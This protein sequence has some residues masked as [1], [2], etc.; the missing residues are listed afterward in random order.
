MNHI[1]LPLAFLSQY[2]VGVYKQDVQ[3]SLISVFFA[4]LVSFFSSCVLPIIPLYMA[5]LSGGTEAI[6]A[7]RDSRK[8][9]LKTM[10]HT[11]FFV[12]GICFAF[13][14]L[15][16]AASGLASQIQRHRLLITRVCG[17]IMILFA[18]LQLAVNYLGRGFSR[19]HRFHFN[20]EKHKMRP[21]VAF[22]L[23]FTFSFAWTPCIGPQLA[24]VL[25][26]GVGASSQNLTY[27]YLAIYC[28]GFIIPFLLLGLF[29][30]ALLSFFKSNRFIMRY[31]PAI[32]AAIMIILGV[33]LILGR[34]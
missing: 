22:V 14:L 20:F 17:A 6:A 25:S 32:G 33:M 34:L 18:I 10:L 19:E 4:G 29:T 26:L 30:D 3:L 24:A 23:G 13:V 21:W 7:S 16:A 12:L 11:L 28:L 15:G 8:R 9:R 31:T 5:Y 2:G 27:L 1:N